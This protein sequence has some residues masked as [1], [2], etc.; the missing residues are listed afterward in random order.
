MQAPPETLALFRP[1][2][3][4]NVVDA[5]VFPPLRA[6]APDPSIFLSYTTEDIPF[7]DEYEDYLTDLGLGGGGHPGEYHDEA[8]EGMSLFGGASMWHHPHFQMPEMSDG[9]SDTESMSSL[10]DLSDEANKLDVGIVDSDRDSIDENRNNWEVCAIQFTNNLP[11]VYPSDD[12]STVAHESKDNGRTS[13]VACRN[14]QAFRFRFQLAPC[15]SFRT[16]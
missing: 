11:R 7:E 14:A 3:T 9:M 8:D 10:A 6:Q 16:G 5:D 2:G 1:I 15:Y 12:D 13:Q 4:P